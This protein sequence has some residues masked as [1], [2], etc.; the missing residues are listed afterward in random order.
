MHTVNNLLG[1][2]ALRI[3]DM[4]T[5]ANSIPTFE[6]RDLGPT[7]GQYG[8]FSCGVTS[9]SWAVDVEV[10]ALLSD[11]R[12]AVS[13]AGALDVPT[14]SFA[15]RW[16][17]SLSLAYAFTLSVCFVIV[18]LSVCFVIVKP[19]MKLNHPLS[20]FCRPGWQRERM[21]L[22]FYHWFSA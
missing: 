3:S 10:G 20:N 9:A 1:R 14:A 18:K 16:S 22:S 7:H 17:L 13:E 21:A 15:S 2:K 4:V 11:E 8:D 6:E 19:K 5:I 12:L